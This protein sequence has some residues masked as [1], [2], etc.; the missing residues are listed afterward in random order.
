MGTKR[1]AS[2]K[3]MRLSSGLAIGLLY[4]IAVTLL[5]ALV[6]S[7]LIGSERMAWDKIG[8]GIMVLLYLSALV[9]AKVACGK[10]RYKKLVVC[11]ASAL[12]YQ[13]FLLGMTM[14]FFGGH[15]DAVI[16]TM[17][18]IIAGTGT[19]FF[20]T[21]VKQERSRYRKRQYRSR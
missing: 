1:N 3:S 16:P 12:I 21:S 8:Y 4:G 7:F 20:L 15:Y 18:L 5:L 17:L 9:T 6:I 2:G 13:L 14:L 10:V 11:I 19:A